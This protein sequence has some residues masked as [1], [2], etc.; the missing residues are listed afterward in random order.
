MPFWLTKEKRIFLDT[1]F[2]EQIRREAQEAAEELIAIA[3][4]EEGSVFVVGCSSSEIIGGQIGKASSEETAA[5]VFDALYGVCQKHHL[6]EI[7]MQN[8][9]DGY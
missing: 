7:P 9:R 4:P 3:K 2:F 1:K 5:V 8:H 6:Y